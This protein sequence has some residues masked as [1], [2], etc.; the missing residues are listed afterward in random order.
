MCFI[1]ISKRLKDTPA[2]P[3]VERVF[4]GILFDEMS[5]NR[6]GSFV[7]SDLGT[8]RTMDSKNAIDGIDN[9]E[10][11]N[12]WCHFRIGTTGKIELSNVHGWSLRNW[13]FTHNGFVTQYTG[14]RTAEKT[15]SLQFFENLLMRLKNKTRPDKVGTIIK[16]EA[17][18]KGFSGRAALYNSVH[19]DM[20]L[21]G[22][23]HV[24]YVEGAYVF[25]SSTSLD[26]DK[27]TRYYNV[28]GL[29]FDAEDKTRFKVISRK[30]DG[31]HLI[32]NFSKENWQSQMLTN[33]LKDNDYNYNYWNKDKDKEKE[34]DTAFKDV[35]KKID[36][37][38]TPY[39]LDLAT[40][41]EANQRLLEDEQH[42]TTGSETGKFAG[43]PSVSRTSSIVVPPTSVLARAAV[44][45]D[46]E[47]DLEV[48]IEDRQLTLKPKGH[49]KACVCSPCMDWND[50]FYEQHAKYDTY[51]TCIACN[52]VRAAQVITQRDAM[53]EAG[54]QV[55]ECDC[56]NCI[57]GMNDRCLWRNIR[58]LG[59]S[60][61]MRTP[62]IGAQTHG[63]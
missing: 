55:K 35:Q 19:D 11:D 33:K 16:K 8:I 29:H 17:N 51:C 61:Y 63:K 10:I 48:F 4:K 7:S 24:Y 41:E 62:Q 25:F 58:A 2:N 27:I 15:D 26:L 6:D 13:L 28:N 50:F 56:I 53:I 22:D 3:E 21:F 49:E 44:S 14:G 34:N 9:S 12:L 18:L 1:A 30:I 40:E 36:E 31:I 39:E 42:F 60:M 52:L 57:A 45:E 23:F 47:K 32:R 5:G 20:Y 43:S 59:L 46:E 38:K 54:L 37:A